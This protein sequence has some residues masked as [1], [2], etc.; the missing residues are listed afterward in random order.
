MS[1]Y[2][3]GLIR[4]DRGLFID[5]GNQVFD[6]RHP[7]FAGGAKGDGVTDD[8]EAI[9]AA[10][11]A[12]DAVG[13][14]IALSPGTYRVTQNLTL[15]RRPIGTGIL[16]ADIG[17][18]VTGF[19]TLYTL[20][21]PTYVAHRGEPFVAPQNT[22]AAFR[23][24]QMRGALVIETDYVPS[25]DGA[26]VVVHDFELGNE[27]DVS[28]DPRD[29]LISDILR[30]RSNH[31]EFTD[32]HPPLVTDILK[33]PGRNAWHIEVKAA[34]QQ[35][36]E[37]LARAIAEYGMESQIAATCNLTI[38]AAAFA[39]V[40]AAYP[41][42]YL[43]AISFDTV[44]APVL[45]D[46]ASAG[47]KEV[48]INH[49]AQYLNASFI[50]QAHALGMRVAIWTVNTRADRDRVLP[51]GPDLIYTDNYPWVAGLAT[52]GALP[53][54]DSF[55]RTIIG[56]AWTSRGNPYAWKMSAT[57]AAAIQGTAL[58]EH[59]VLVGAQIPNDG[60]TTRVQ[61]TYTPKTLN[62]DA[63]RWAGFQ[64]CAQTD[65]I[66]HSFNP[67]PSTHGGAYM[68]LLR[69]NGTMQI[70]RLD[71]G[72][73][74]TTLISQTLTGNMVVDTPITFQID[75]APTSVTFRRTDGPTAIVANDT[76]YR[77]GYVALMFTNTGGEFSAFSMTTL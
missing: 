63:T 37:R 56:T 58:Q 61:A 70:D 76:T 55:Q 17:I 10:I 39:A 12:A 29:K 22:M 18:G 66:T 48:G 31:S 42:V 77:G 45:S 65:F 11:A 14:Q 34:T 1:D 57:G 72:Q 43:S 67:V 41:D 27:Y 13:G 15:K 16:K 33:Q 47:V 23:A 69:Q 73:N 7:D 35:N 60:S 51:F 21:S 3:K 44:N 52:P 25:Q 59:L 64:V 26:L 20:P 71:P 8:T 6:V 19:P 74:F 2:E 75:I 62:A 53:F 68:A 30:A 38:G 36:L 32:E 24:A 50:Q 40:R 49:S 46:F 5:K 54:S 4:T 28:G 9:Q